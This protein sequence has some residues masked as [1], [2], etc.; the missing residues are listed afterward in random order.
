MVRLSYPQ[1]DYTQMR[2]KV[3]IIAALISFDWSLVEAKCRCVGDGGFSW[4]CFL[5]PH[6][7]GL[8][9]FCMGDLLWQLAVLFLFQQWCPSFYCVLKRSGRLSAC[10]PVFLKISTVLG[11]GWNQL[12]VYFSKY[13]W[14]G[15]LFSF[16]FFL[17]IEVFISSSQFWI[18]A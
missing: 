18:S 5:F 10:Q 13:S 3:T 17:Q 11:N 14:E 12:L 15:N 6:P 8:Q 9:V 16:W 1:L 7:P 2:R 4:V